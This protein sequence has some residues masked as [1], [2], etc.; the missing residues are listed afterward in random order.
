MEIV[1]TT[2]VV[3]DGDSKDTHADSDVAAFLGTFNGDD[4]YSFAGM[5]TDK[6]QGMAKLQDC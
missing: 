2:M 1:K 6:S 4:A 3:T 5:T